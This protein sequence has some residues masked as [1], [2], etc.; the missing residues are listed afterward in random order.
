MIRTIIKESWDED[1]AK[2]P[3][4]ERIAILLKAEYRTMASGEMLNH[5]ERLIDKSVRSFRI[6]ARHTEERLN[7]AIDETV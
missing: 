2:R 6:H 5:S 3:T 4:F 7:E 1:P